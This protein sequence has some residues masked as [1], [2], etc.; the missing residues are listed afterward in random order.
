MHSFTQE[1]LLLYMYD[2]CSPEKTTAI[3]EAL[4]NDWAL[5]EMLNSLGEGQDNLD[6]I[7]LSPRPQTID[8]ILQYAEKSLEELSSHA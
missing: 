8:N 4:L 1:D 2:E 5:R 6:D 7:K 3:R